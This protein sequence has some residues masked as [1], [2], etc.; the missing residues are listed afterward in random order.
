MKHKFHILRFSTLPSTNDYAK[1]NMHTLQDKDV[2]LCNQQ[3]KGRGRFDRIWESGKD[4]TFTMVSHSA[5]SHSL[6]AP[7]ALIE[8]LKQFQIH[9]SIKWPNDI[10]VEGK[11]VC[12]ILIENVF[13]G[14]E[15]AGEVIGIG[16]NLSPIPLQL[17][18]KATYLNLDKDALLDEILFQY[19]RLSALSTENILTI[20]RKANYLQGRKILLNDVLWYVEDI[21]EEGYLILT[22]QETTKVLKSEEV[23]LSHI[24]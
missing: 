6:I 19:E 18:E 7:C 12:G 4:L 15:L 22:D 9:A 20:Y 3:T 23:S 1:A 5:A 16:V 14:N 10:L 13:I 17:Q 8:A 11:K 24:Y 2:I 21:S